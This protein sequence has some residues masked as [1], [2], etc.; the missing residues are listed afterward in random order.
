MWPSYQNWEVVLKKFSHHI[1]IFLLLVF[2]YYLFITLLYLY[3]CDALINTLYQLIF[4]RS[5]RK[6]TRFGQ[7]NRYS[8][9]QHK[10]LMNLKTLCVGLNTNKQMVGEYEDVSNKHAEGAERSIN[11]RV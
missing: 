3:W 10:I 6:L 9:K 5:R 4:S 11:S 8:V 7:N 1:Y 2:I